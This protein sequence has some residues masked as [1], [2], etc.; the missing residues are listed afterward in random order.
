MLTHLTDLELEKTPSEEEIYKRKYSKKIQKISKKGSN[1]S[2]WK[3]VLLSKV[4]NLM[5]IS[6]LEQQQESFCSKIK[7]KINLF[8]LFLHLRCAYSILLLFWYGRISTP[9]VVSISTNLISLSSWYGM[10]FTEN[11]FP[12]LVKR[13]EIIAKPIARYCAKQRHYVNAGIILAFAVP[14]IFS[15][16]MIITFGLSRIGDYAVFY[17]MKA[18]FNQAAE[19]ALMFLS[20]NGYFSF[21]LTPCI[22]AV[23]HGFFC[24]IIC[25]AIEESSKEKNL[26]NTDLV[27]R[28]NFFHSVIECCKQLEKC[29]SIPITVVLL[30]FAMGI[31]IALS[32][33]LSVEDVP[34]P[35]VLQE[36]GLVVIICCI[37]FYGSIYFA[38]A[39]PK[40]MQE[41][42]I[43]YK[44]M[45]VAE[46][47]RYV[48]KNERDE[49]RLKLLKILGE[50]KMFQLTACNVLNLNR[51][52]I[53]SSLGCYITYGFLLIQLSAVPEEKT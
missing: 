39:I 48:S 34:P 37:Y 49:R 12:L 46:V 47:I 33:V 1:T 51:S 17:L 22:F 27:E 13:I 31:F 16:S 10:A 43:K 8:T 6:H 28:I 40:R 52:F 44:M 30:Y 2:I 7:R 35:V 23:A 3:N 11:H 5:G 45:Y 26:S 25:N 20:G 41:A 4:F 50:I 32:L 42:K 9:A 24:G 14:S 36:V 19:L 29:F 21:Y 38:S 53:V 15:L 18:K